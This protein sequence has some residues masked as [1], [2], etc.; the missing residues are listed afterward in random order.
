V[1]GI[2][3]KYE[4]SAYEVAPALRPHLMRRWQEKVTRTTRA[5]IFV[6]FS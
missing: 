6:K 3:D 2:E 5:L 1:G 4:H